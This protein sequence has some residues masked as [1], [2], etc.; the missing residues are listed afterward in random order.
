MTLFVLFL[1]LFIG[2]N[3]RVSIVLGIV[4]LFGLLIFCFFRF[5]KK[6]FIAATIFSS[7]GVG[8]SFIRP[9]FTKSEYVAVVKEVKE[10]YFIVSSTFEQLYIYQ[11]E[12]QYEIG[13]ILLIKGEKVEINDTAIESSF[14]FKKY[15]SDKGVYHQ[16][17]PTSI[18]V[19]F[20]TP[21]RLHEIK[22]NFLSRF[23]SNSKA[24][25]GSFLFSMGSEEE[26]YEEAQ[27][28]HLM[29]LLS[30]SGIYLTALY[31]VLSFLISYLIKNDKAK[32]L[33]LIGL[34]IPTL[35]FSFP[36]FVVIKFIFLKLLRWI[37]K[38]F[39]KD[40]FS[41]LEVVSI[42]AIFFLIIDYHLAYQSGFLLTYF[43]PI[44]AYLFNQSFSVAR[45]SRKRLLVTG[46]VLI[47][48]IPFALSFYNEISPL[49]VIYQFVLAPIFIV[50]YFLSLLSFIGIPIYSLI[51]HF[52]DVLANI[53][54]FLNKIDFKIYGM[55]MTNAAITL[56]EAS[57]FILVY[58][59]SSRFK[60]MVKLSLTVFAIINVFYF[61][62]VQNIIMDEVS[63]INVGQGD[64]TLIRRN[65]TTILI[66]TGG[67]KYQD[68]AKECLIPYFKKQR[69]YDIDLLIT[70]HDDFDHSGAVGSLIENFTVKRY[71]KDYEQFP[72]SIGGF[73]L[74]NYNI[75]PD[76]WKEENDSS[77]VIGLRTKKHN[78]L[79]M[80]DAPKKIESQIMR[81]YKKIPCDILKIGHHGSKTSSSDEFIRY[82]SPKV[83]IISCGIKNSYGHPHKE[84]LGIL[85]KYRVI[86]RRTDL[87]GTITYWQ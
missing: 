10:N 73:T 30:N 86:I 40:K 38:H 50:Y 56:Y 41:Y 24:L 46:L 78:Y 37:N 5:G 35:V 17:E 43:I 42:S 62:P 79:I 28:L 6:A 3:I 33:I 65:S 67:N 76:L 77:L 8:L 29:R 44:T 82:L 27:E 66:D 70:T 57:Y 36:R 20:S 68:I 45:Q 11:K 49:S 64:A 26:V 2:I 83:G 15:L 14:D 32:E 19:K 16:L 59:L 23:N 60:P 51:N 22:K 85:R 7:I 39:L 13:D 53:I 87:E 84:V 25:I 72:I 71:V 18:K 48:F 55:E 63:F 75:Y 74:I 47:S 61:I 12:H 1:S 80:G 4:E 21:F 9:S 54:H 69:I 31:T 34:F 52:G 58:Y 81:D